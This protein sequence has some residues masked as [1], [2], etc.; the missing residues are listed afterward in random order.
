MP[1]KFPD[2]SKESLFTS[3]DCVDTAPIDPLEKVADNESIFSKG[4]V[5]TWL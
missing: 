1:D 4:N 3:L 2:L 5:D